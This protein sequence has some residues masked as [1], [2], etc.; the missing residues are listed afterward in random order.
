MKAMHSRRAIFKVESKLL[1]YERQIADFPVG[2]DDLPQEQ[3]DLVTRQ[4]T[5][6]YPWRGQFSP[7]LV[8][9]LL[10]KFAG[11]KSIVLDPYVGSGTTLFEAS[12][13]NLECYG[14]EI[15]P[16]AFYFASMACFSNLDKLQR[17]C[18]FDAVDAAIDAELGSRL[19]ATLFR[20]NGCL[21]GD[22]EVS[23]DV[24]PAMIDHV[25]ECELAER[26]L[27]VSLMLTARNQSVMSTG[28]FAANQERNRQT[29]AA[30]PESA[31]P[32]QVFH[33]DSRNLP[34]EDSS[35]DLVI[36]SPPY[37]NVFNYHQNYRP[38]MEAIG[39]SI[40][41][42]ARS[43]IGSNRKHRGN[44]FFTVIQYC[45]DLVDSLRELRRVLR[46]NGV[47]IFVI[48]RES[49]V[50]GVALSNSKLLA[51][52]ALA[53]AGMKLDEWHERK[54]VSRFGETIFEDIIVLSC[55]ANEL[56]MPSEVG[57]QIGVRALEQA[58]NTAPDSVS[59]DIHQAVRQAHAV[60]ASTI[61]HS[62]LFTA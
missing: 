41:E 46:S 11:S 31:N 24:A 62:L 44:R 28:R 17:V 22:A 56:P 19:P 42:I 57:Q 1:E 23:V 16:A 25:R 37:V 7:G 36:T 54:F 8:D 55:G 33:R 13:R 61:M 15:N 2:S 48:G 60:K 50:R 5:S 35:I 51:L 6:L 40:L 21:S 20:P 18:V 59:S 32:C 29:L 52:C 10:E 58:L 4:R 49:R 39:W 34:L 30:L 9:L 12:R 38:T 43:E 53:G 26:M 45:I 27:I 47:A 14:G 3:L